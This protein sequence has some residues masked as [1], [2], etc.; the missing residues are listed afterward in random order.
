MRHDTIEVQGA[1]K[2]LRID[3][4]V[5]QHSI[6]I[7][8]VLSCNTNELLWCQVTIKQLSSFLGFI[9]DKHSWFGNNLYF[10]LSFI[11][12]DH[13]MMKFTLQPIHSDCKYEH[14]ISITNCLI[15]Y[16]LLIIVFLSWL[17][18]ILWWHPILCPIYSVSK[19]EHTSVLCFVRHLVVSSP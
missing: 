6:Q 18:I 1:K 16:T 15:V 17:M 8:A 11:Y 12:Y 3:K 10:I 2:A 14:I 9:D 4:L 7:H 19:Y 13:I 5:S